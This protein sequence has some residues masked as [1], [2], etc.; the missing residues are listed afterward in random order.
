MFNKFKVCILAAAVFAMC[1]AN[2]ASVS[3][4]GFETNV[5]KEG[6]A[7]GNPIYT[8]GGEYISGNIKNGDVINSELC[9][10]YD[11]E[12]E[13]SFT[14]L[15]AVF[16]ENDT[17]R[18]VSYDTQK[19]SGGKILLKS[20]LVAPQNFDSGKYN[21]RTFLW[22]RV[23]LNYIYT[24]FF[25]F[26]AAKNDENKNTA[27][28]IGESFSASSEK[29]FENLSALKLQNDGNM[30]ECT[31]DVNIEGGKIYKLDFAAVGDAEFD[32]DV[33]DKDGNSL[34]ENECAF[35]GSGDWTFA[36]KAVFAPDENVEASISFKNRG[37]GNVSYIDNV[38]IS[39]NLVSN[40]GFE[41]DEKGYELL[42]AH[43]VSEV[44]KSGAKSLCLDN[45]AAK[46]K[47]FLVGGKVYDFCAYIKGAES[48]L[49][50]VDDGKNVAAF[51]KSDYT[52]D[53]KMKNMEFYVENSGMYTLELRSEGKAYFDDLSL[54]KAADNVVV[55]GDFEDG[56]AHWEVRGSTT[57]N[58]SLTEGANGKKGIMLTNRTQYYIGIKQVVAQKMADYGIG[59]YKVSGYVK[60]ADE[61]AE[62]GSIGV[63][64]NG[65]YA[66]TKT[67]VFTATVKD[68]GGSEWTY[69]EAVFD[70]ENFG[71]DEN[72]NV[73]YDCPSGKN[74]GV[75]YFETLKDDAQSFC[76]SDIK[77]EALDGRT[78]YP[79]YGAYDGP[80]DPAV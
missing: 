75:L 31:Q 46:Q 24:N 56:T 10:V 77:M 57:A 20:T 40:E 47:I 34:I 61:D 32:Y 63:R 5:L 30:S 16:D 11:G 67:K 50:I 68:V 58:I 38:K 43:S 60:Y 13:Q 80:D 73:L 36:D 55:N 41:Y 6:V 78:R 17:M 22:D 76:I 35:L 65:L 48:Y 69:F 70:I 14:A 72:G 26:G 9:V 45:G 37:E 21:I 1:N 74:D 54:T 59:K 44:S 51:V 3:D 12:D 66:G 64:F 18:A 71:T 79:E 49:K 33:K 4:G 19:I 39:E 23:N 25:D 28:S 42:G 52:S 53:F 7:V 29:V 8:T 2:A 62:V 27:W 15:T